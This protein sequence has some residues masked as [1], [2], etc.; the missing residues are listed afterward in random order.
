MADQSL[1]IQCLG[2][3][4][5]SASVAL[6]EKLAFSPHRLNAA[7]ARIGC[8]DDPAW[9][10]LRE[11]VILSTCNRVELY[12]V[13]VGS[14]FDQLET[15]LAEPHNI[16]HSELRP[17]LYRLLDEGAISH[18][19]DVAAGLDSVVLGEPQ[20]LGQVTD[21]YMAARRVGTAG[22][23]LSRLFQSAIQAGKRARTETAISHNP[24][25]IASVAIKLISETVPDVPV[26]KI[27]VLGAGEMAELVVESLRKRGAGHFVVVNRTLKKAQELA[28]R[29]DGQAAS[30]EMLLEILPEADIVITSTGAPHTIIH[31]TMVEKSMLKREAQPVVFMD[32]A[33]PRDVDNDINEV[34]G[35]R[36]F[37]MDT[38][39]Q[40][41]QTSL[42]QRQAEIPQVKAI[43]VEERARFIEYLATLD[44]LP[45]II[46][47][48]TRADA[49]RVAEM[50]RA[51]RRM[52][53][54]SPEDEQRIDTLTRSIV[55]KILHKPTIRLREVA[56]S[57]H[58][59]D[60]ADITRG[61]FGLD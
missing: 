16:R 53:D 19:M 42:V 40:Q 23:I 50:D 20:I 51:I 4:H 10:N 49:I 54:L 48:R 17:A 32:I 35:V 38:L 21:A 60:Y 59:S 14:G 29:W 11:L 18:L 46:E 3:N 6:R 52:P 24:A 33:V 34:P 57:S 37:D 27:M 47:L 26:S 28:D 36:L 25:S 15:L 22:K 39:S 61:L 12:A 31:K 56:G 8:G 9:C 55:K 41:L 13:S 58:A 2:L 44:I 45:L 43:L 7:L 1:H 5:N 30:L